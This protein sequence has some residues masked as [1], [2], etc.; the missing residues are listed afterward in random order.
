MGGN[1][2]AVI[3]GETGFIIPPEDS[4]ALSEAL[5]NLYNN[6]TTREIMGKKGRKRIEENFNIQ[7]MIESMEE[8]YLQFFVKS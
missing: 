1:S 2:E 8:L 4:N 3:D 5:L 6:K 7:D